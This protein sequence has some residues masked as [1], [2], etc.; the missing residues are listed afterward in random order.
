MTQEDVERVIIRLDG[1]CRS[2]DRLNGS[3][4]LIALIISVLAVVVAFWRGP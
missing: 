4:G 2:V 1:L 3:I